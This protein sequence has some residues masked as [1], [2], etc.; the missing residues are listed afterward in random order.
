MDIQEPTSIK[1]MFQGMMPNPPA[2]VRGEVISVSPL[3]IKV[4]NDPKLVLNENVICLP[5]H[6]SDYTTTCDV[7]LS[8]G[9][10]YSHTFQDGQHPH[11]NSGQHSQYAGDG[12]HSHP[13][14]EGAHVNW[15]QDFNI[16]GAV[17]KIY[18]ALKVGDI[19]FMLSYNEGKKYY[20][21]DREG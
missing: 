8:D 16:Y 3:E 1:E 11:G 19:V 20:I 7:E 15:L 9:S 14:A 2:V 10:I 13:G 5:R 12:A 18:N 4:A 6:L 21:I 17:I